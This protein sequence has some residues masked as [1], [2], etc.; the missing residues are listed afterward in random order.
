M[1][2][3]EK[4]NSRKTEI[5]NHI[6]NMLFVSD[7][8]IF[9]SFT[10][11]KNFIIKLLNT[12]YDNPC[13]LELLGPTDFNSISISTISLKYRFSK[14]LLTNKL[15]ISTLYFYSLFIKNYKYDKFEFFLFINLLN[16]F[17]FDSLSR[18]KISFSD[19]LFYRLDIYKS[20]NVFNNIKEGTKG[21]KKFS[22]LFSSIYTELLHIFLP[23]MV[24]LYKGLLN[25][26]ISEHRKSLNNSILPSDVSW[27]S[28]HLMFNIF[29]YK[30]INK[31]I[32]NGKKSIS[33]YHFRSLLYFQ[34]LYNLSNNKNYILGEVFDIISPKFKL[35]N[36]KYRGR[37]RQVPKV[38]SYRQAI[39]LGISI[40]KASLISRKER[41]LTL[42]MYSELLDI[43]SLKG[44]SFKLKENNYKLGL[45]NRNLLFR[46]S[47]SFRL[48]K[49]YSVDKNR[50]YFGF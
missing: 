26:A 49:A 16:Y 39:L 2:Q 31:F 30:I 25:Q 3:V 47:N 15:C 27:Q 13:I 22:F 11:K 35:V 20:F 48:K 24:K 17:K 28:K 18:V 1:L 41:G 8:L 40:F 50:L 46:R 37:N 7:P 9:N 6:K 19:L 10:T 5:N 36:L 21:V 43:Y 42:K 29:F 44:N 32:K 38:I 33:I 34:K 23:S 14:V 12:N 4:V 45:A